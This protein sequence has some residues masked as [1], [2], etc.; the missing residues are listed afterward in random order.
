[1][2]SRREFARQTALGLTAAALPGLPT[3]NAPLP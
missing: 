1:M 2:I 3:L